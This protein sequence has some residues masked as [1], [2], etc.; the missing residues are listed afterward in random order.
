MIILGRCW[1]FNVYLAPLGICACATVHVHDH[2]HSVQYRITSKASMKPGN[3]DKTLYDRFTA[4]STAIGKYDSIHQVCVRTPICHHTDKGASFDGLKISRHYGAYGLRLTFNSN[5]ANAALSSQ[6]LD[7]D[8][9]HLQIPHFH[10]VQRLQPFGSR[11]HA[12]A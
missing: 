2:I 3:V 4:S 9:P 8:V 5:N 6:P 11:S 7:I 10:N 1:N 12:S